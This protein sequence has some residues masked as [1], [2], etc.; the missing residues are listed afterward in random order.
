MVQNN[1]HLLLHH[2][3]PQIPAPSPLPLAPVVR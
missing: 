1:L 3:S 2:A